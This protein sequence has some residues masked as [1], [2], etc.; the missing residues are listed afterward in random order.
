MTK[1]A[2]T[3]CVVGVLAVIVAAGATT[4]ATRMISVERQ[5][6]LKRELM[7]GEE[8][9]VATLRSHRER[10]EKLDPTQQDQLRQQAYAFRGA[11]PEQQSQIIAAWVKFNALSETQQNDYR[12]RASWLAGVVD[13]LSDEQKQQL[14][15]MTPTDRARELLRIRQQL[16]SEGK[17]AAADVPT[18][19]AEK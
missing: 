12:R 3:S 15:E 2:R 4:T 18:E 11:D 14:L 1:L 9:L 7:M 19:S 13:T 6:R 5:L 17:L 16:I 8:S 10:W